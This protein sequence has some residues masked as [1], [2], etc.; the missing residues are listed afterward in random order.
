MDKFLPQNPDCGVFVKKMQVRSDARLCLSILNNKTLIACK[1]TIKPIIDA[2]ESY[3]S[4]ANNKISCDKMIYARLPM[5]N[6]GSF[7]ADRWAI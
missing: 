1:T 6:V 7:T 3:F 5:M 4:F 2:I